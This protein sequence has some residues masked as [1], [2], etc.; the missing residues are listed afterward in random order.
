MRPEG[1]A[2]VAEDDVLDARLQE[3]AAE[4]DRFH[5]ILVQQVEDDREVVDAER[6]ER[7]LVGPDAAEVLAVPVDAEHVPE[8]ARVDELLQLADAGVIEEQ[9]SRQE[10]ELAL[11]GDRDELVDLRARHR[12][13][14]LDEDVLPGLE[15][16]LRELVV[17]RHR[18]RDYDGVEL[19]IGEHLLEGLRPARLRIPA[20]V[21]LALAVRGI[22]EPGEL[23]EVGEVAGEVPAPLAE[24]RLPDADAHR[25]QT[26]SEFLP[27]RPVA[28]RRSTTSCASSTSWS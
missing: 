18:R 24:P 27:F 20:L 1:K 14:L 22:G 2:E 3:V 4:R 7:V 16:E 21:L 17:G 19:R 8:L 15:G 10:H 9:V 26:L 11:L 13:R 5:R 28:F 25:R 6:P 12:G 23:R